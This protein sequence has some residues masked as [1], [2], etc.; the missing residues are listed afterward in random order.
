MKSFRLAALRFIVVLQ[1]FWLEFLHGGSRRR[2]V[3]GW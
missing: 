3:R 2:A 1:H